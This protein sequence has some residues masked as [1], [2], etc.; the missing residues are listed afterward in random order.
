MA[1][2]VDGRPRHPDDCDHSPTT[3]RVGLVFVCRIELKALPDEAG[4]FCFLATL[5]DWLLIILAACCV[6][7]IAVWWWR[8]RAVDTGARCWN[9][10]AD[11]RAV[12]LYVDGK[13]HSRC[14]KCGNEMDVTDTY[15]MPGA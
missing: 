5:V 11:L 1:S 4:L 13:G 3:S 12:Q 2:S 6:P 9:C 15:R 14:P 10:S 8:R 7:L